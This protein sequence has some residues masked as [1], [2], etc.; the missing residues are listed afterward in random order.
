LFFLIE[1]SP[2]V[3]WFCWLGLLT[4]KNRLSYNLYCVG[5]DVKHCSINQS[6]S[7]K[8]EK[9][10]PT[11]NSPAVAPPGESV[12]MRLTHSPTLHLLDVPLRLNTVRYQRYIH[13]WKVHLM[14]YK[15]TIPQPTIRVYLHSFS[16]YCL[17]NTRDVAKFEQ[18]LTL[19]QFKVIQGHRSWCQWKAHMWLHI[20]H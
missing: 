3:L 19:Q 17:R 10:T 15:S 16:C 12:W 20:S 7:S 9:M 8:H 5:K 6:I 14:G 1:T 4:C 2:S 11:K 13:R 18:N